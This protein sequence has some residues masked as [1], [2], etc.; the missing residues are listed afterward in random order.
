MAHGDAG[1]EPLHVGKDVALGE[2]LHLL[3]IV[4]MQIA[5][6]RI[7]HHKPATGRAQI[8]LEP[9]YSRHVVQSSR[10]GCQPPHGIAGR[11]G[12]DTLAPRGLIA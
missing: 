4:R 7:E 8:F 1:E 3:G 11:R 9:R 10:C 6:E 12:Q 2:K 5:V